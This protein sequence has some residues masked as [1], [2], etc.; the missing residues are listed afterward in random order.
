MNSKSKNI[1]SDIISVLQEISDC[2]SGLSHDADLYKD[3]GVKSVQSIAILIALE[4]KFG[5]S[6]QDQQFI[7][8]RTVRELES[9]IS[10]LIGKAHAVK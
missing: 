9:L 3:L 6:I 7:E 2:D 8:A 10:E 5:V 4:E 1:A